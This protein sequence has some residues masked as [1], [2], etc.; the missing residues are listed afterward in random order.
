[1]AST[2]ETLTRGRSVS[3]P[4]PSGFLSELRSTP[5]TCRARR[6]ASLGDTCINLPVLIEEVSNSSPSSSETVL[7]LGY[8][9]NLSAETFRGKRGIRPISQVNVVVP[10]LHMTF[11][12]PGIPYSEPCF[13]NTEY[14]ALPTTTPYQKLVSAAADDHPDYRKDHWAKGLVG[15]VYEVTK[16]DYAHI[17]ATEGGG[18]S[19][20][21]V[22][23]DCYVLSNNPRDKVPSNP[24][25]S[26]DPPF[27]AHTLLAPAQL[28][29]RQ[30]SYAQ[31]SARYLKLITDGAAEH[32]LPYEYQAYLDQI[33]PFRIT[34]TKQRFGQ[35][36][37][38]MTW[39]PL[40]LCFFFGIAK[41]FL[42]PDG[43][44]P[45]WF[46]KLQKSIFST[47]W[48]SY[49]SVFKP[50]F[51]DGE[52]TIGDMMGDEEDEKALL[53]RQSIDQY[54]SGGRLYTV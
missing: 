40:F 9:S 47:C 25:A 38:L 21:D 29:N 15:V 41:I 11:N 7:Y 34:T 14:R 18:A 28:P 50:I 46:A 43:T 24:T 36:L 32:A 30:H 6:D 44:Y 2:K 1:M 53:V 45:E 42:K 22:V 13:G 54:G 19:Y 23:V 4:S 20:Q 5:Q 51:G 48:A 37:F 17:I 16:A 33:R 26:G 31:P 8:G 49:D 3:L 52:R 12:L 10:Q 27:K 35:F 39:I